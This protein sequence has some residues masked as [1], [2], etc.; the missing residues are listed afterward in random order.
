[1]KIIRAVGVIALVAALIATGGNHAIAGP[2]KDGPTIISFN[3][4]GLSGGASGNAVK[5][6]LAGLR[7]VQSAKVSSSTGAVEVT[8]KEGR[9]LPL[10]SLEQAVVKAAEGLSIDR[11]SI[12]L[13]GLV[14]VD[15]DGLGSRNLAARVAQALKDHAEVAGAVGDP[16]LVGRI[17]LK[18]PGP[19][20]VSLEDL[21]AWAG[22]ASD[23]LTVASISGLGPTPERKPA[24]G[25][26]GKG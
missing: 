5:K 24:S 7:E 13:L 26:P 1:M 3:V 22:A 6:A 8:V 18:I 23:G 17:H 21:A 19:K 11:A 25:G 16:K 4:Q 9:T 2:A 20:A 15:F 14:M 12:S 10:D